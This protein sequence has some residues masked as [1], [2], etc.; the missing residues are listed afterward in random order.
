MNKRLSTNSEKGSASG[1]YIM[2]SIFTLIALFK[3]YMFY[4]DYNY[5]ELY[6]TSKDLLS[7]ILSLIVIGLLIYFI[8]LTRDIWAKRY[9]IMFLLFTISAQAFGRFGEA[10]FSTSIMPLIDA[11][12]ISLF[13]LN[14]AYF[15]YVYK[16]TGFSIFT[17]I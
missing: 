10:V 12:F 5:Y 16:K 17:K 11:I 2:L 13:C 3:W 7:T 8:K 6:D 1:H 4:I 14:L 9:L 15:L